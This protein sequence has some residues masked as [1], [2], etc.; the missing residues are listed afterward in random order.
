MSI[1]FCVYS[2]I[3][4]WC[5]IAFFFFPLV[6][7]FVVVGRS[8]CHST[9]LYVRLSCLRNRRWYVF[10]VYVGFHPM[11]GGPRRVFFFLQTASLASRMCASMSASV[12]SCIGWHSANVSEMARSIL[13]ANRARCALSV[14]SMSPG[15]VIGG[16][17]L[18]VVGRLGTC[19]LS[20]AA[21]SPMSSWWSEY[22]FFM[23]C[24]EL[25]AATCFS[26][27]DGLYRRCMGLCAA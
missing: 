11:C 8:I 19:A 24:I 1:S 26:A 23:G 4:E 13:A 25:H 22:P 18:Y 21:K 7:F 15:R 6:S 9:S 2:C 16:T 20:F 27:A 5:L 17:A 14:R 10:A 3:L 12:F